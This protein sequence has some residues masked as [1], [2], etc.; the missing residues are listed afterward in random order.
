MLCLGAR[1]CST[2]LVASEEEAVIIIQIPRC[3]PSGRSRFDS[4]GLNPV[5]LSGVAVPF[6]LLTLGGFR[7]RGMKRWVGHAS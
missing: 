6:V 7:V 2:A 4:V 3:P 5:E 1:L